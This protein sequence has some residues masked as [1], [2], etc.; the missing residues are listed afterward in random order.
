M[1]YQNT[2]A[3]PR[4]ELNDVIQEG[5]PPDLV[6]ILVLPPKPMTLPTGHVPKIAV[7]KGNLMRATRKKRSPG[8]AFD[9]WQSTIDDHNIVLVQS[10]E[11]ILLPD[12]QTM[13]YSDYFA[14]ESLYAIEATNR[15]RRAH[16]IEC[17][18]ALFDSGTFTATNSTVA[19]T[20]GNITTMDPVTDILNCIRRIKGA[21]EV[22]NTIIIPGPVY[23]RL[24]V[25][26]LMKAWIAGQ[27]APGATVTADAIQASFLAQGI[28]KVYVAESY[29]NESDEGL[30]DVI[31]PIWPNT[32]IFVGSVQ[33]GELRAGGVGRT[34]FWDKEGPLFNIQS[35]R[36]ET[37]KSNVIRAMKT[38]L[39]DITNARAGQLITTQYS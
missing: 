17:E 35:Y 15:L 22:A 26:T 28:K 39:S 37:R 29:V 5:T 1:V 3:A 9:R 8:A 23:D 21:G 33:A 36:D 38:T 4:E 31:N 12:E 27:I 11:E 6:G 2:V 19:Y 7:G 20:A 18:T 25:S 16:E 13:L 24:R 10:P 14:F 30:A 34:F 32:Y